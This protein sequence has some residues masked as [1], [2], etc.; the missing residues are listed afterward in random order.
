MLYIDTNP[1]F[2]AMENIYSTTAHELQHLINYSIRL[3]TTNSVFDTWIDEG[4]STGA[5]YLFKKEQ[6]QGR[7]RY[8]TGTDTSIKNGNNFYVWGNRGDLLA[9]YASAYMFFQWL[10]LNA[11]N[12][13]HVYKEIIVSNFSDYRAI[14]Q[15]ARSRLS[16]IVSENISD[17]EAW[18]KILGTWLAANV[19]NDPAGSYG[20]KNAISDIKVFPPSSSN[21]NLAPGEAVYY[22]PTAAMPNQ[23][24]SLRHIFLSKTNKTAY[25][26]LTSEQYNDLITENTLTTIIT[27]NADTRNNGPEIPFTIGAMSASS[28]LLNSLNKISV[29]HPEEPP[30][31]IYPMCGLCQSRHAEHSEEHQPEI[32]PVDVTT[33]LKGNKW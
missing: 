9:E 26:Q 1:G 30:P 23:S 19:I 18:E 28:L 25:S 14:T 31:E 2:N 6:Q 17:E 11:S 20:Y 29:E 21:V 32:Y 22:V 3:S 7:I 10:G 33:F 27:Y 13:Y 16:D 24:G 8:F 4:L 15:V 12:G 5:E